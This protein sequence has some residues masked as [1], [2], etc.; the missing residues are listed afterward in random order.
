MLPFI[1]KRVWDEDRYREY[2][3][4]TLFANGENNRLTIHYGDFIKR[5]KPDTRSPEE[6]KNDIIKRAGL[7]VI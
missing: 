6:I 3:A 7:N 5:E 2:I 4:E 1:C